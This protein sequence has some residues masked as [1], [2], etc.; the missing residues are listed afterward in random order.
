MFCPNCSK[1]A[2]LYTKKPCIRC[3]GDVMNNLSVICNFCANTEKVCSVCLKKT[4]N[5]QAD[6]LKTAGCGPCRAK[7]R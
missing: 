7:Q 4:Q 3:Q 6:K 2:L 1:L 5:S